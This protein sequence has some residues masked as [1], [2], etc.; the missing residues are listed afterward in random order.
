MVRSRGYNDDCSSSDDEG[1]SGG[2]LG[3]E[4]KETPVFL[5]K[6]YQLLGSCPSEVACWGEKGDSFMIKDPDL[7]AQTVIPQFFAHSNFS[8]C[9]CLRMMGG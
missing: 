4:G 1:G 8:S 3:R 5:R 2:G 6:T 7:F 9:K